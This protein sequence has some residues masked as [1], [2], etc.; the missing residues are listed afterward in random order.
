MSSIDKVFVELEQELEAFKTAFAEEFLARVKQ[1][2]PVISG[3][4]QGAWEIE[5]QQDA[6]EIK[7]P[8]EYAS[9]VEYGTEK[10][11]PRAMLRTTLVEA[12]QIAEIAA[13]RVGLK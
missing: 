5:V 8:T 4:L 11:A 2:T 1:R 6:A 13:R 7:N 12:E 10:M 9:Y 3:R